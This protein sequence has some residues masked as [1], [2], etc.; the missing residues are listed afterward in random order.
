MHPV[1]SND[2][3][4]YDP[5]ADDNDQNWVNEQQSSN[6]YKY[7]VDLP[8]YYLIDVFSGLSSSFQRVECI[9]AQLKYIYTD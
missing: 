2:E 9:M 1:I 6:R 8:I 4:L 5:E 7:F 3:L